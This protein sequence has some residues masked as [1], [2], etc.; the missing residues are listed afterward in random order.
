MDNCYGG[1]SVYSVWPLY[2]IGYELHNGLSLCYYEAE[3]VFF[4]SFLFFK[5]KNII[6]HLS[7]RHLVSGSAVCPKSKHLLVQFHLQF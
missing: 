2:E 3:A 7:L 4:F 1:N 5:M 6:D